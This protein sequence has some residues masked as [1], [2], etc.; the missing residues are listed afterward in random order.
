MEK[1][2]LPTKRVIK[3]L[4]NYLKIYKRLK[5]WAR[6]PIAASLCPSGGHVYR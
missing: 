4:Q 3:N 2:H 6:V 1:D 5:P